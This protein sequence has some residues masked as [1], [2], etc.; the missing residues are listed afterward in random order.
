M[1]VRDLDFEKGSFDVAIDKGTE[2]FH[3]ELE[4][5]A[6]NIQALWTLC[7]LSKETFG[8]VPEI[9]DNRFDLDDILSRIHLQRQSPVARRK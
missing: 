4:R 5:R 7:W 3:H 8:Y 6:Q 1:D 9:Q 2:Q